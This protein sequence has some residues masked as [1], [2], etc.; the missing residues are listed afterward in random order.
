MHRTLRISL[1]LLLIAVLSAWTANRAGIVAEAA[2]YPID[3][4]ALYH[5]TRDTTYRSTMGGI[6]V[7]GTIK[8]EL[9]T[10]LNGPRSVT[11][12]VT[13]GDPTGKVLGSAKKAANVVKRDKRY[14]Y[15]SVSYTSTAIGFDLYAFQVKQGTA[16]AWYSGTLGGDGGPGEATK[17]T[18]DTGFHLSVYDAHFTVPSW[19]KDMVIYQIFPDRFYNGDPSNDSAGTPSVYGSPAIVRK[20]WNDPVSDY[21]QSV[22][23]FY[24]GDLQGVIDK[25]PYLKSLGVNTLYLNPIFTAPTNHKYDTSDYYSI[26]PRFGTIGTF[27]QLLSAAHG[28]GMHVILDGVFNHTGSDSVYF[29]RYNHY[30][31]SGAYQSKDSPYYSWYQFLSWPNSYAAFDSL[32]QMPQLTES[33]AVKDFIFRKPD[34]VA[35]HWLNAGTDGWRLDAG[36]AQYKSAQWWQEFRSS[37]KATYPNDLL[38]C[39]C[40]AAPI[41]ATQYL[42]GTEFDGDMNYRWRDDVLRFFANG[43]GANTPIPLTPHGFYNVLSGILQDYPPQAVQASM[44]VLTTHDTARILSD[45]GDNVKKLEEIVAFQMTWQGA[46]TIYYGDEAGVQNSASADAEYAARGTY[47]WG[48]ENTG[49]QNYYKT[50]IAVR[51]AHPA[52]RDGSIVPLVLNDNKFIFSYLRA[53]ASDRVAVFCNNAPKSES[54]TARIPKFSAGATLKDAITGKRYKLS[55]GKVTLTIPAQ[56]ALVLIQG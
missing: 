39:E 35:Q 28:A 32:G 38:I 21:P 19:T 50:M 3:L 8:L 29:N 9:R 52:L 42:L 51:A 47:P 20:N 56:T 49:L 34:S 24:G 30:P 23:E 17:G 48:S 41:D 18:P 54:I 12:V 33:D 44:N 10:A 2:S 13:L 36:S 53:D 4:K 55:G 31:D 40:D 1:L 11:L 25:L 27:N 5:D 16:T 15:W 26:D 37:V 22:S 46:P 6:P 43:A 45:V 7:G 14:E